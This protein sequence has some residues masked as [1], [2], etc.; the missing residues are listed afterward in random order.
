[1][2]EDGTEDLALDTWRF[3]T[4]NWLLVFL[5]LFALLGLTNIYFDWSRDGWLAIPRHGIFFVLILQQIAFRLGNSRIVPENALL[6]LD[7]TIRLQPNSIKLGLDILVLL[8]LLTVFLMQIREESLTE[9]YWMSLL[10]YPA[11][12]AII[13]ALPF[14]IYRLLWQRSFLEI[15]AIGLRCPDVFPG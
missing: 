4:S 13:V 5:V 3:G 10:F 6:D 15:S 1:M 2:K 9:R 7:A 12:A 8:G 11:S 14:C